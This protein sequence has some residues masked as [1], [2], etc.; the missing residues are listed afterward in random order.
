MQGRGWCGLPYCAQVE[1]ARKI[2][3]GPHNPRTK[4]EIYSPMFPGSELG[5][6]ALAGGAA[7]LGI[8]V[9]FFKYYVFRD[10]AW[11]YKTRPVNFD[12]DVALADT[13]VNAPVNAVD[14]NLNA[15][16]DRGGKLLL[17]DG[18]NDNQVP[19]KVA[20]S[21]YTTV[22]AKVGAKK[23]KQSMRFF[24]V[25]GMQ[26]GPGTN[27]PENVNFDA[28]TLLTNWKE[29]GVAPDQLIVT[30][31]EDG[32]EI[33]KRLVCQYPQIAVYNGG[34]NTEDPGSF[35]CKAANIQ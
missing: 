26:H 33:G 25:P 4:A 22:V 15:F 29:N 11:D 35:Q 23:V 8:P 31:F 28:L 18:W 30:H 20:I 6:G 9:E 5:W 34:G 27:G 16:F 13:P 10:P 3:E 12:G 32:M 19:S 1:A 21:Y 17:V 24:M 14:P 2:Y 7:P